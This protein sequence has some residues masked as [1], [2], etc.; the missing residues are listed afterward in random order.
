[1]GC[2]QS[3][4]GTGLSNR[5]TAAMRLYQ[6]PRGFLTNR[7]PAIT[8]ANTANVVLY[9]ASAGNPNTIPNTAKPQPA[10]PGT[11]NASTDVTNAAQPNT[12]K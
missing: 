4:V 11:K 12:L 6:T 7:N 10:R 1:M 5:R 2:T 8:T 3:N 9:N